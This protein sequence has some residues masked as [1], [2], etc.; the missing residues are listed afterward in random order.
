MNPQS[1]KRQHIEHILKKLYR[2]VSPPYERKKK[3]KE[4]ERFC[5]KLKSWQPDNRFDIVSHF[6]K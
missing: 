2:I 5:A 4:N 6:K 1:I 3:R